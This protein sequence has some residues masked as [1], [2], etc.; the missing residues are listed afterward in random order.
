[1]HLGTSIHSGFAT[2]CI[3]RR[4]RLA[5]L[6]SQDARL[7]N[8]GAWEIRPCPKDYWITDAEL[9]AGVWNLA[10]PIG[11]LTWFGLVLTRYAKE[12]EK[13]EISAG[14]ENELREPE[15]SAWLA[16]WFVA[17]AS[18]DIATCRWGIWVADLST[19][20]NTPLACSEFGT[21][22]SLVLH[23]LGMVPPVERRI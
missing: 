16:D 23:L 13:D 7:T 17:C 20:W 19:A 1:M 4:T 18:A 12:H 10:S 9:G 15:V 11:C 5:E 2:R 6:Q 14:R 3:R 8:A 21:T 22:L